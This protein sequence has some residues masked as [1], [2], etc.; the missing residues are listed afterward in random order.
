MTEMRY[1]YKIR[2]FYCENHFSYGSSHPSWIFPNFWTK[3]GCAWQ[4]LWP[5][6]MCE[7]FFYIF[8][9]HEN[10]HETANKW[11]LENMLDF[12]YWDI[13]DIIFEMF[14]Y[15]TFSSSRG[16]RINHFLFLSSLSLSLNGISI[17]CIVQLVMFCSILV[18]VII[19]CVGYN[20]NFIS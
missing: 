12:V 11:Q 5:S 4:L 9:P 17:N 2:L 3:F 8:N 7:F 1:T 15:K 10:F 20:K 14:L 13:D 6:N 18:H 16:E 19:L